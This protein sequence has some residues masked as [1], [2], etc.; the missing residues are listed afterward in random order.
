MKSML[1]LGGCLMLLRHPNP[2]VLFVAPKSTRV[3]EPTPNQR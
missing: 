3:W 1:D 2:F